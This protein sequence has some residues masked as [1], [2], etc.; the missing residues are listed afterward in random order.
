MKCQT[1]DKLKD[2]NLYY[3]LFTCAYW[4]S[5][6]DLK[7]KSTPQE[8]ALLFVFSLNVFWGVMFFGSV[9]LLVGEN[10]MSKL[11]VIVGGSLLYLFN[12]LLFIR[13]RKYIKI[14]QTFEK[15]RHPE[16]KSKRIRVMAIAFVVSAVLAVLI[17]SL[18]N[19][20]FR[21]WLFN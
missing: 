20:N 13:K 9:N 12:Y 11:S 3:Y 10:I 1:S 19:S 4:I 15:I 8:Y 5:V 7:E 14:V 21:N 17:A 6:E 16:N 18:N 2:M